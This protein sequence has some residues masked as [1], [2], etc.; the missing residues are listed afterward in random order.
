METLEEVRTT[1]KSWESSFR[2]EHNRAATVEDV[3]Q[4][5]VIEHAYKL[6]K[7]LKKSAQPQ[8]T[9]PLSSFNPF[10][11]TKKKKKKPSRVVAPPEPATPFSRARKRL[12]GEQVSPSPTKEKRRRLDHSSGYHSSSDDE[13]NGFASRRD[14]LDSEPLFAQS[15]VKAPAGSKAFRSL[16]E[17]ASKH[18]PAFPA[19]LA[20][21]HALHKPPRNSQLKSQLFPSRASTPQAP[22]TASSSRPQSTPSS[23]LDDDDVFQ[24]NPSPSVTPSV[25]QQ[26]STSSHPSLLC[27]SPPPPDTSRAVA[28]LKG[29]GK[30]RAR[31]SQ[32]QED[33][34]DE[35]QVD[36]GQ[37]K[38]YSQQ[39]HRKR[40]SGDEDELL[41][42]SLGRVNLED[43]PPQPSA[44]D[45]SLVQVQVPDRLMDVLY[46]SGDSRSEADHRDRVYRSLVLGTREEHYNASRG[47]EVWDAGEDDENDA[48]TEGEDDWEGEP[49]PWESGEL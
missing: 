38:L 40:D 11:P 27:P 29:K 8:A 1:I 31:A 37:V 19:V 33:E 10:S 15:P 36:L 32:F 4:N 3:R 24:D 30:S 41:R 25:P 13:G 12:R 42:G 22:S 5:K 16:F 43:D 39:A 47:G 20:S 35:A 9:A 48:G 45:D 6:Y 17:D 2:D 18:V 14:A 49:V 44:P 21:A 23:D 7:Q 46:I 26:P 34:D 28:K